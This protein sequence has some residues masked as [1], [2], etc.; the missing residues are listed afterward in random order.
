MDKKIIELIADIDDILSF[1]EDMDVLKDKLKHFLDTIQQILQT[2]TSCSSLIREYLDAGAIGMRSNNVF[3]N[4]LISL[5]GRIRKAPMD[6]KQIEDYQDKL[7]ALSEKLNKRVDV[8]M[9]HKVDKIYDSG[10]LSSCY[11][12]LFAAE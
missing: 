11:N 4:I 9:A 10:K 7:K 1:V 6:K 12:Q 2:I 5:S 8:H 3:L